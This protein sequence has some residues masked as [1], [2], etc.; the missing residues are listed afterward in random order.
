MWTSIL[1]EGTAWGV[2][3]FVIFDALFIIRKFGIATHKAVSVSVLRYLTIGNVW[4]WTALVLMICTG[5]VCARL[6]AE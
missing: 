4:F 1:F 6:L 3:A 2:L 5:V